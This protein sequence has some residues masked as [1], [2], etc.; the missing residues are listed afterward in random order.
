MASAGQTPYTVPK[1]AALVTYQ[2]K[3]YFVASKRIP[4]KVAAVRAVLQGIRRGGRYR[5]IRRNSDPDEP[6]GQELGPR[7]GEKWTDPV[8]PGR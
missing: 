4:V 3:R 8:P 5:Y 2:E 7:S 1:L 6:E